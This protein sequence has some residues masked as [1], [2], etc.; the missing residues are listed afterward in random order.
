MGTCVAKNGNEKS[1]NRRITDRG[2]KKSIRLVWLAF[3]SKPIHGIGNPVYVPVWLSRTK[4]AR[5]APPMR[6]MPA[7]MDR[8]H[9][10]RLRCGF[11]T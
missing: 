10:Q 1:H 8:I 4:N 11:G 2:E 7:E 9:N 6:L 5:A 3:H